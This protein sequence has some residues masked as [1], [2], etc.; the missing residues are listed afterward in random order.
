MSPATL[1]SGVR[2]L[3]RK[4]N[5][6]SFLE[7]MQSLRR[8][9]DSRLVCFVLMPD[10]FHLMVN[11]RD[12]DI[13]TW[14]GKLKSLSANRLVDANSPGLFKKNEEENQV[15]QESFK[16]LRLWS[17][18][19]IWQKINYIHNNPLRAGL[20]DSARDYRWSSFRSFYHL[21]DEELLSVDN[22]WLYP[23]DPERL[24][25]LQRR[26]ELY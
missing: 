23:E 7:E 8:Q 9:H 26:S 25:D 3:G 15:W 16:T 6:I 13:Q 21:E 19:M 4:Q 2:S 24:K 17:N 11:P 22:E 10:H 14:I 12:G 1:I 20:V 5:C 18:W